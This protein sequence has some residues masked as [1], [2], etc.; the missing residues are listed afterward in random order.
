MTDS[1]E[2]DWLRSWRSRIISAMRLWFGKGTYKQSC[3][4]WSAVVSILNEKGPE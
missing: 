2:L 3:E 4:R 1:E